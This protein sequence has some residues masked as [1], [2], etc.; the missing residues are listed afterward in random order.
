MTPQQICPQPAVE[1][2]WTTFTDLGVTAACP[3]ASADNSSLLWKSVYGGAQGYRSP[4]Q[5]ESLPV[6]NPQPY[7]RYYEMHHLTGSNKR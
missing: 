7:Y 3:P 5:G 6:H 2:R 4:Q 1:R